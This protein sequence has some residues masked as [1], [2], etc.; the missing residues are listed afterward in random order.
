MKLTDKKIME[1]LNMFC[2][3]DHPKD[4]LQKPLNEGAYTFASDGFAI[5]W[6]DK[7][8][9]PH[10]VVDTI[11]K[12]KFNKVIPNYDKHV[13][14]P[15]DVKK[16]A[17]FFDK[18][19]PMVG[20]MVYFDEKCPTCNGTGSSTNGGEIVEICCECEGDK[21][22]Q[23]ERPT[24]K[25]IPDNNARFWDGEG[26]FSYWQISRVLRL[27]ELFKIE[28]IQ[29]KHG[30]SNDPYYYEIGAFKVLMMP[31][32]YGEVLLKDSIHFRY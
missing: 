28:K 17:K 6:C 11:D 25:K 26:M 20:E 29:M 10:G 8:I 5:I 7:Y 21:T 22:I 1:A 3:A 13:F 27:A 32:Q 23:I 18:H 19:T 4:Y 16:A 31:I 30:A 15:I 2:N 12:P 9:T 14:I 24:G